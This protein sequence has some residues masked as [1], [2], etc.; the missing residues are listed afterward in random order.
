MRY[1]ILTLLTLFT[2]TFIHAQSIR[3]NEVVSSNSILTDEDGDTPDWI[4]LYN[5]GSQNVNLENWTISDDEKDLS[6][7]S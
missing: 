5:D 3:F 2:A 1:L 6:K 4:E 7:W